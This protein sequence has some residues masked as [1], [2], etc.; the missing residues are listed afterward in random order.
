MRCLRWH[1]ADFVRNQP[2]GG[3]K[4][5]SRL[6]WPAV[7]TPPISPAVLIDPFEL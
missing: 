2:V 1:D 6:P 7:E 4:K 5:N 3:D